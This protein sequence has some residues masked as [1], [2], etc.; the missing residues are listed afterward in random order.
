M[1]KIKKNPK[2]T[3][4]LQTEF[5]FVADSLGEAPKQINCVGKVRPSC[6]ADR[7]PS[8]CEKY[9]EAPRQPSI[10]I[11]GCSGDSLAKGSELPLKSKFETEK[12]NAKRPGQNDGLSGR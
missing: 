8:G 12:Q 1:R 11:E 9:P 4:A 6:Y 10:Q 3:V 2:R 5:A 7:L